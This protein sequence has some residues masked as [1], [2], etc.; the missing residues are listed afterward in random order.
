MNSIGPKEFLELLET[1]KLRDDQVIDVR[2]PM[3]WNYYH[4]EG[5]TLLPMNS[6]PDSI[7]KLPQDDPVY[8]VCA[9]GVRSAAVC[10]YLQRLGFDHVVNVEGGMA[11]VSGYRG[12]Q[13][14]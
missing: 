6:I 8:I 7:D 11:A 1:G 5:T 10:N 3:E 9:H 13:Y 14:D 2:E 4:L 12:F